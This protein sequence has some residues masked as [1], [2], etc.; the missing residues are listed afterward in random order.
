MLCL[1]NDLILSFL[2]FIITAGASSNTFANCNSELR[3]CRSNAKSDANACINDCDTARCRNQCRNS[4]DDD[5][6]SCDASADSCM[7]SSNAVSPQGGPGYYGGPIYA[8]QPMP[9]YG[10][11]IYNPQP[12]PGY[13]GGPVYSPQP[14]PNYGGPAYNPQP[15]PSYGGPIYNPQPTPYNG[16]VGPTAGYAQPNPKPPIGAPTGPCVTGSYQYK[17]IPGVARAPKPPGPC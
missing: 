14:T 8:P 4:F 2:V 16:G 1:R 11:P 15:A 17:Q 9:N 12:G 7:Q 6:D 5:L 3:I 13:G 10:G